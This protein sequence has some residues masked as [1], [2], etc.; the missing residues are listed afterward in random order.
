MS[1]KTALII[2]DARDWRD[3]LA[4]LIKDV[5]PHVQV[6]IADSLEAAK[7]IIAN[8]KVAVA[9]IDIRL[10]ERDEENVD[11][12]K[13]MDL[14][15]SAQPDAEIYIVTG[16][17]SLDTVQRS[18]RPDSQ[19]LRPSVDYIEKSEIHRELVPRLRPI[20]DEVREQ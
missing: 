14:L 4:G 17:A 15:R 3:M 1:T 10:D 9:L 11:G 2:D 5:F 13:F 18:M 7:A 8:H 19:G 6:Q 16:Y 12:L 20:L